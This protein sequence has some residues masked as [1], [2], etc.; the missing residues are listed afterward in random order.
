MKRLSL[1]IIPISLLLL[2]VFVFTGTK[3]VQ[4]AYGDRASYNWG[5]W[6]FWQTGVM[7]DVYYWN[8]WELNAFRS[9]Y[10]PDD[11]DKFPD[12]VGDDGTTNYYRDYSQK[13]G[14]F[15]HGDISTHTTDPYP[16]EL[17]LFGVSHGFIADIESNGW[18]AKWIA[19]EEETGLPPKWPETAVTT[20]TTAQPTTLAPGQT[21]ATP[22]A[23]DNDPYTLRCWAYAEKMK[24]NNSYTFTFDG[25]IDEGAVMAKVNK[26]A[27][28]PIGATVPASNKYA[29]VVGTTVSGDILF[30]R[31]F[32]LTT[33]KQHFKYNFALDSKNTAVKVEF[34]FGAYL[35]DDPK[36]IITHQEVNWS[37]KVHI[38]NCD[39]IQGNLN[40]VTT[41]PTTA[42]GGGGGGDDYYEEEIPAKVTGLKAKKAKKSVKLSWKSSVYATKYQ[43]N[44]AL[45]KNFKGGKKKNTSK[46]KITIKGLKSKKTYY[47]RVRGKNDYYTGAWSSKKKCKVK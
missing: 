31:N 7:S 3:N 28:D 32:S 1:L 25:Y 30:V 5:K 8:Q 21:T 20:T 11:S 29:K 34:M 35:V 47:F 16:Y 41:A 39:F 38:E 12:S 23:L 40:E 15:K 14:F 44:Y 26:E 4:A 18:S 2:G 33:K 43:V 27:G 42:Y 22:R 6:T 9:V 17:E 45:K 13:K 37:G 19:D 24:K 10:L 46:R 36:T